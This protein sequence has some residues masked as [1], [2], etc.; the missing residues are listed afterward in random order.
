MERASKMVNVDKIFVDKSPEGM[1]TVLNASKLCTAWKRVNEI[2]ID[3]HKKD[4]MV[5]QLKK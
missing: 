1:T 4:L 2:I 5:R 3:I